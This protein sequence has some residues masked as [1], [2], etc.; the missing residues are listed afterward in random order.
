MNRLILLILALCWF[1]PDHFP[2]WTSFHTEAP[3]FLLSALILLAS[4]RGRAAT[5]DIPLAVSFP[6]ALAFI[7]LIQWACGMLIFGGDALVV[8]MYLATFSA[9][10]FW[11]YHWVAHGSPTDD[12][13]DSVSLLLLLVG[14]V[15]AFQVLAQWLHVEDVFN[16]WVLDGLV[17]GRPRGNVGQPNQAATILMM[18]SVGA[19]VLRLR[20]RIR[21]SV[22]WSGLLVLLIAI[23]LTQSRTALLSASVLV[24]L[25]V[26]TASHAT[27]SALK[28]RHVVLW[29]LLLFGAA[30]L[31]ANKNVVGTIAPVDGNQL[32]AIGTRPLIWKQ[33]LI[34]LLEHPWAGWGWLQIS[35]A[36]QFGVLELAGTEQTN[37][38]HNIVLDMLLML[39][40]PVAGVM[41]AVAGAWFWSRW[42]AITGS[43][44]V[45]SGFFILI[46]FLVHAM[47]EFPH[48]YAYFLVLVG[49]LLGAIDAWSSSVK[50]ATF[51]IGKSTILVIFAMW[52]TLLFAVGYEY[53]SAEEDFR[54]NRFENRKLGETPADYSPPKLILLTQLRDQGKAMRLRAEP[55]MKA[56]DIEILVRVS[57]RYSWAPIQFRTALALALNG[58]PIEATQQLRTLKGLFGEDIY[59][60]AKESFIRLEKEKYP[61]LGLVPLP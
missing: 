46:P 52:G 61:Q 48:A 27:Y 8:C 51:S 45:R 44:K 15:S 2:P 55:N 21:A 1:V 4:W 23:T 13:L 31:Y 56:E 32:V 10:W 37:Y 41:F 49:L 42:T 43:A 60:E 57:K 38:A 9:A 34:A 3:A 24:V 20:R 12:L 25:Y 47:L 19:A 30:W 33:L 26:L 28:R 7:A 36:Q 40:L 5:I 39:G 17:N 6:F 22:M 16:G 59:L 35:T 14:L 53:F 54:I 18:G 29:W 50:S 58:R 11:G